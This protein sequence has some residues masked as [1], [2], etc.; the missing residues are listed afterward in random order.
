MGPRGSQVGL[1]GPNRRK[2]M[3][4]VGA[5]AGGT[6]TPGGAVRVAVSVLVPPSRGAGPAVVVRAGW[7][8]ATTKVSA[9]S[10]QAVGPAPR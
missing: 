7:G 2:V 4:P 1:L 9:G 10:A 6:V 8:G 5:G 3:V